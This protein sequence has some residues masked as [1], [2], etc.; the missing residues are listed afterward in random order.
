MYRTRHCSST[1]ARGERIRSSSLPSRTNTAPTTRCTR[2]APSSGTPGVRSASASSCKRFL[3]TGYAS[4]SR[5]SLGSS[6]R[7]TTARRLRPA[8]MTSLTTTPS[9]WCACHPPRTRWCCRAGTCA[10]ATRAPR[11]SASRPTSVQS[12]GHRT[13]RCSRSASCSPRSKA[14]RSR[15]TKTPKA[16]HLDSTLSRCRWQS[17]RSLP[18]SSP[19]WRQSTPS[20]PSWAK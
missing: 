1:R 4:C 6:A 3:S 20:G 16:T 17:S 15:T 11:S 10:S 9:A 19:R 8:R 2:T 12:A 13:T 7:R 5:R 14:K 18:S